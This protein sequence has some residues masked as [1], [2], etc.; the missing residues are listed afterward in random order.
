MKCGA[1][2]HVRS[3]VIN[4]TAV[5]R[6]TDH[7]THPHPNGM[8]KDASMENDRLTVPLNRGN[9]L[10]Y[11]LALIALV[12]GV[13]VLIWRERSFSAETALLFAILAAVIHFAGGELRTALRTRYCLTADERGLAVGCWKREI[14]IPWSAVARLVCVSPSWSRRGVHSL[15]I[16]LKSGAAPGVTAM[17]G[18][19]EKG[20]G[21]FVKVRGVYIGGDCHM[22]KDRLDEMLERHGAPESEIPKL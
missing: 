16:H 4:G 2:D 18:T 20:V 9:V 11:M 6:A 5:H 15:Y 7:S 14:R 3:R 13:A 21:G 1:N 12:T 22:I 17:D 19:P 8:T 10:T